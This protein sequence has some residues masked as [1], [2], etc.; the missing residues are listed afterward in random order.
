MYEEIYTGGYL[1]FDD[2][3]STKVS[4]TANTN[5]HEVNTDSPTLLKNQAEYL[6]YAFVNILWTTKRSQPDIEITV[7]FFALE[8]SQQ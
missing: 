3:V 5:I 1:F 4:S 8:L 7:A 2:G 6:Y